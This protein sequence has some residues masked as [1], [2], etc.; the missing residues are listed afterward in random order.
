MT[1][2]KVGTDRY[3]NMDRVTFIEPG[4]GDKLVVRF[5]VGGGDFTTTTCVMK[6]SGS[7]ADTLRRWLDNHQAA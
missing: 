4:R 6:L 7:E 1:I 2:I 3:I 5:A